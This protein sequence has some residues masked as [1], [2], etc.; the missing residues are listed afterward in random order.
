MKIKNVELYNIGLYKNDLI[1]FDTSSKSSIFIWGNNGAG[2]TTLLNSIKTVLFGN[3][4]FSNLDESQY[5]SF[6]K[7]ELISTR[8]D[9]SKVKA[10]I[11]CTLVINENFEEFE[12]KIIR[13]WKI[14][15]E[16]FDEDVVIYKNERLLPYDEKE[17]V[18]KKLKLAVPPA[19]LDVIIFDGENAIDI[20]KKDEMPKLIKNI[21]YAVFGMDVYQNL[22]K[23]LNTYLK[24]IPSNNE[25]LNYGDISI[26][27]LENKY[28]EDYLKSNS[29]NSA[30]NELNKKRS[31]LLNQINMNLKRLSESTGIDFS[32]ID[33]FKESLVHAEEEKKSYNSDLKYIQ[34]EILP[35]KMLHKKLGNL[36]LD[37]EKEK[38]YLVLKNISALKKYFQDSENIISSLSDMERIITTNSDVKMKYYLDDKQYDYLDNLLKLLNTYNIDKIKELYVEKNKSYLSIKEKLDVIEKLNN[39]TNSSL[40]NKVNNLYSDLFET[41]R[42]LA[43]ISSEKS[44]IDEE[45]LS[46]KTEYEKKK[47]ELLISKKQSNSYVNVLKYRS[48]IEEYIND[49]IEKVCETLNSDLLYSIRSIGFRNNSIDKVVISPKTFEIKLYEKGNKLVSSKLFSAGEKQILLGLMIKCSLKLSNIN[50]FFMFDTPVGRLDVGNRGVFTNEVIFRVADQVIVYATD[51]D[52][53]LEDYSQIKSNISQELHLKRNKNDEIVV[54]NESIY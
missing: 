6:I 18:I 43:N 19:L 44:I 48:A 13:S 5:R 33:Q 26:S 53:T 7:N 31:F 45:L 54:V 27:E 11:S 32:E 9:K 3:N 46:S 39:E 41:Q 15:D 20:L 28:K 47:K 12:Y 21:V 10:R 35:I 51:S 4:A 36:Y 8:K 52:Y 23:D 40:V 1:S 34:E 24:N 29:V 2:K 14:V 49:T 30:Y 17:E 50:T 16:N 25:E 42:N 22:V 38:P 37:L